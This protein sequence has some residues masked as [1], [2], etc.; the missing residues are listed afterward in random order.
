[1]PFVTANDSFTN[2]TNGVTPRRWLLQCN[3]QLAD[4]ITHTLGGE[5]WTTNLSL[6]KKLVPMAEDKAFRKAFDIIK[7]NNKRRLADVLESELGITVNPR[8]IFAAQIKR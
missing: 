5:A 6:L 1:M 8:S 7:Q 2:V 4:L 3:P